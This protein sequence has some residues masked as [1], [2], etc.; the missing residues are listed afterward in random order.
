MSASTLSLSL[1]L[2]YQP[3]LDIKRDV[4]GKSHCSC[5]ERQQAALTDHCL[6]GWDEEAVACPSHKHMPW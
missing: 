2:S 1:L 3:T 4:L 6:H 5:K